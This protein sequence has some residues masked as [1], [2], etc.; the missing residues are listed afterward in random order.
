M[1]SDT[2]ELTD[3]TNDDGWANESD[4]HGGQ[5]DPIAFADIF[6][7]DPALKDRLNEIVERVEPNEN[8]K[9]TDFTVEADEDQRRFIESSAETIRLL[10]PAG[11]GRRNPL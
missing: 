9:A 10:A 6:E 4:G 11:S 1:T 5:P 2:L 8:T 7:R 3:E